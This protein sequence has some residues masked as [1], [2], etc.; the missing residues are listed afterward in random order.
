MSN[1]TF[2]K[3]KKWTLIIPFIA[4][5]AYLLSIGYDLLVTIKGLVGLL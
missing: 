1:E 5:L 4:F 3:W 2:Q